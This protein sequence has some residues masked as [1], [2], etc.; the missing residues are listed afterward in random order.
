MARARWSIRSGGQ[1]GVDRAALDSALEHGLEYVGW[2]P[3]G[4]WAE[5]MPEPPGLLARYPLLTPTSPR[6]PRQRTAWNVRDSDATLVLLPA[7]RAVSA[8]TSP[9][10]DF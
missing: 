2:C 1:T 5:D 7:S 10:T 8:T 4:G 6:D 3:A 9:G